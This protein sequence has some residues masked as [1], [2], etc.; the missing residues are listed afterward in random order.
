VWQSVQLWNQQRG[1]NR[2]FWIFNSHRVKI[3]PTDNATVFWQTIEQ[4]KQ[5]RWWGEKSGF[6]RPI[7]FDWNNVRHDR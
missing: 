1:N 5:S 6:C 4:S 2:S 7:I 3:F